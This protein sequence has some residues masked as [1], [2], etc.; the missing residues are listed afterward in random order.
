MD[1]SFVGIRAIFATIAPKVRSS[2]FDASAAQCCLRSWN[3]LP[4]LRSCRLKKPSLP[5]NSHVGVR[6]SEPAPASKPVWPQPAVQSPVQTRSWNPGGPY[7]TYP[8]QN[9]AFRTHIALSNSSLQ[10]MTQAPPVSKSRIPVSSV[11]HSMSFIRAIFVP[12]LSH[13]C[14]GIRNL[15]H[16]RRD[17]VRVRSA[18]QSTVTI[19]H[20]T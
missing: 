8:P 14:V 5:C 6:W 15:T 7:R 12:S 18:S 4:D 11:S 2:R 10:K 13:A 16:I 19:W 9:R 1:V 20:C 3:G 17:S